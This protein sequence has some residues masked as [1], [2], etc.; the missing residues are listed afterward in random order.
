MSK[1][2]PALAQGPEI[3]CRW[4]VPAKWMLGYGSAAHFSL[5]WAPWHRLSTAL[6]SPAHPGS[7]QT[8]ALFWRLGREVAGG[9]PLHGVCLDAS[10]L[11]GN[12]ENLITWSVPWP[13]P[14]M[15]ICPDGASSTQV[16]KHTG[17]SK[18]ASGP[19][20]PCPGLQC[21][22]HTPASACKT[23]MTRDTAQTSELQG[24]PE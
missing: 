14:V 5:S 22:C 15:P 12:E 9:K 8:L 7:W 13:C 18:C 11:R 3:L 2:S 20:S 21:S 6:R 24:A 23:Y 16:H 19:F 4:L 1:D 17:T 10:L